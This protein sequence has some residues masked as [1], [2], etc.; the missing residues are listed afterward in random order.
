MQLRLDPRRPNWLTSA[1]Q[2]SEEDVTSNDGSTKHYASLLQRPAIELNPQFFF[3]S[4]NKPRTIGRANCVIPSIKIEENSEQQEQDEDENSFVKS[5]QRNPFTK[6]TNPFRDDNSDSAVQNGLRPGI[7]TRSVSFNNKL[8]SQLEEEATRRQHSS[9]SEDGTSSP[10][11]FRHKRFPLNQSALSLDLSSRRR[12]SQ[13]SKDWSSEQPH[14]D[15]EA[16]LEESSRKGFLAWILKL[17]VSRDAN[18][19]I[20]PLDVSISGH[21]KLLPKIVN[22]VQKEKQSLEKEQPQ[23]ENGTY[24]ERLSYAFH[25]YA[26]SDLHRSRSKLRI[27]V[28]PDPY[29]KRQLFIIKLCESLMRF[30]T[31]SH[32]IEKS[33]N[34]A[35]KVLDVGCKFLYFPDC[36]V[37][38]FTKQETHSADINIVHASTITDLNRMALVN[39]VYRRVIFDE[40][41]ATEGAETLQKI[42]SFLPLY[43]SWLVVFMHG[44]ASASI[45][46]VAFGGGWIDTPVGFFLGLILGFLRVYVAPRSYIFNNLFEIIVSILTTFLGRAFGSIYR[47]STEV[48]CFAALT[49]GAIVLILPGYIVF[50]AVLELQSKSIVAGGVRLLYAIIF[51]LFLS[52][53]ITIGAALYGWMDKKATNQSTCPSTRAVNPLYYILLIPIFTMCLLIVNQAHPRQWPIQMIISCVGYLV[54]Y[55]SS[56]HFG[57]SQISNA[58]GAFAIGCFGNVYSHFGKTMSFAAVLPA[59]FVQVPSGFAA[60][61]GVSAGL[62]TATNIVN[63]NTTTNTTVVTVQDNQNSSLQFG[64]T[65]V[66]IAIGIAVGFFASSITIYPFFGINQSKDEE[67]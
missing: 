58:I 25:K 65:M 9:N 27:T 16:G 42:I 43:R 53:G 61:G 24:R 40:L 63:H 17:F 7:P 26:R 39:E 28:H 11:F 8:A 64:F 21:L 55:F 34:T 36:M 41:G 12:D 57:T 19:Y 67:D 14:Q 13:N 10:S 4:R 3:P 33:L 37:L 59:I 30:G 66:Q 51:S 22:S 23:P 35:A 50:C 56:L 46:P 29:E 44:L 15:N 38:S 6:H 54:N 31:P 48:F 5:I 2:D 20:G 32:R 52:F 60:Q 18:A 45:L 47:G 62:Q 1:S 49:E